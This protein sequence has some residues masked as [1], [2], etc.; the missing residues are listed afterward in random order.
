MIGLRDK[1]DKG[2]LDDRIYDARINERYQS[3]VTRKPIERRKKKMF[4]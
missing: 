2:L 4:P 1:S 3:R